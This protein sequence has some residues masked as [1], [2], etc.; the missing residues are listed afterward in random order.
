M[1]AAGPGPTS[2]W[3]ISQRL[4]LHYVDFGGATDAAGNAKPLCV[5]VHGGQDHCRNWD[6]V[7]ATLTE[8]YHVIAPDL[9]GHGDSAWAVGSNYGIPEYILDLAQL[10]RH[11]GETEVTLVGHSLGGAIVLQYAGVYPE[12]VRKVCAIEGMGPPPEMIRGLQEKQVEERIRDYIT[13]TQALSGRRPREYATL[14]DAEAR[15]REANPHLTSEMARHLTIHGVLR[16]ENGNYVWKFDN[17]VRVWGPHRYDVDGV[18]RLWSRVRCPVLLVRGGQSWANNPV[19]DGRATAFSDYRY[20]E[21]QGA[22]HWVH[23]DRFDEFVGH[24]N[25]FL[26]ERPAQATGQA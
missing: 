22:G 21:V 3:F 11:V 8:R 5:L 9:R 7:A 26:D 20:A 2:H 24:L 1:M 6:F 10:L 14:A 16:L 18:K 12:H 13:G 25:E 19:E 4:R 17:Y 15:M 23:H